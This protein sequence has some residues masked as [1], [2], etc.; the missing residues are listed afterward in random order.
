MRQTLLAVIALL[1]VLI[2]ASVAYSIFQAKDT[3]HQE[4]L[5]TSFEECAA[6]GNPVMESFPRQCRAGD[7]TFTE[8]IA[9]EPEPEEPEEVSLITVDSP[10]PNDTITSPVHIEGQARGYWYFEASFPVKLY[11]ADDNLIVSSAAQAQSD[12]MT[13]DFVPFELDLTFPTPATA[14]GKLVLEKDNPSGLPENDASIE[15]PVTF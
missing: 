14:T 11:D 10:Q 3:E 7:R 2:L 1:L 12:W 4:N 13:E 5:I 9:E 15:I 6:A 8:I